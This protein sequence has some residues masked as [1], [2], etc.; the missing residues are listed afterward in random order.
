M[1]D[2][3]AGQTGA[4]GANAGA[5]GAQG[6]QA[7]GAAAQGAQAK[8]G[9]QAGAQGR[10]NGRWFDDIEGDDLRGF[11]GRFPTKA[12]F[13][14]HAV[15]QD[16]RYKGAIPALPENA[17]DEQKAEHRK[18]AARA[19]GVPEKIDDYKIVYPELPKGQALTDADKEKR[20][21][22]AKRFHERGIPPDAAS[23]LVADFH[24]EMEAAAA[25]AA[26]T[27]K[28]DREKMLADVRKEWGADYDAN[29]KAAGKALRAYGG[30]ELADFLDETGLGNDP[31][32]LKAFAKIGLQIGEDGMLGINDGPA[33]KSI[34][35]RIDAIYSEHAGKDSMWDP[36]VQT[37]LAELHAK[38]HGRAPA[39]GRAA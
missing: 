32:M 38:L 10:Q 37:E 36:K 2:E 12:D 26:R 31:R 33:I 13:V 16:R 8:E 14:K 1:A 23:A 18:A 17:T 9:A 22:W 6:A 25:D 5:E 28:T 20:A 30:D 21:A 4:E 19:L 34:Q 3:N 24:A 39:D 15:E 7:Q 35:E 27:V 11:V 29:M